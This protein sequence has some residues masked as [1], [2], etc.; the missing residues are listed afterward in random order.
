M[1]TKTVK[2]VNYDI[3]D[4]PSRGRLCV[5]HEYACD[6]DDFIK[7]HFEVAQGYTKKDGQ[8]DY[9]KVGLNHV[10]VLSLKHDGYSPDRF[11]VEGEA[12]VL[13]PNEEEYQFKKYRAHYDTKGKRGT[14]R[15]F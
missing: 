4:G 8:T 11:I 6:K 12:L 15:F 3:L 5:A 9:M 7:V 2:I 1:G 10:S 13:L 14:I